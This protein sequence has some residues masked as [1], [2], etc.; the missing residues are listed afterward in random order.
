MRGTLSQIVRGPERR[1]PGTKKGRRCATARCAAAGGDGSARAGPPALH[2]SAVIPD[3]NFDNV[4]LRRKNIC[5]RP[6]LIVVAKM[7]ELA[8][9]LTIELVDQPETVNR[10]VARLSGS[11]YGLLPEYDALQSRGS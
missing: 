11:G 8:G 6:S 1:L 4:S 7:A 10:H 3:F 5:V 9:H 2:P